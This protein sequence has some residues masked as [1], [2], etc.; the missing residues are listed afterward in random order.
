MGKPRNGSL[1]KSVSVLY[2]QPKGR[3]I[4]SSMTYVLFRGILKYKKELI[5][6]GI[7]KEQDIARINSWNFAVNTWNKIKL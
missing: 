7:V 2:K 1:F 4:P 6:K 5:E 3:K